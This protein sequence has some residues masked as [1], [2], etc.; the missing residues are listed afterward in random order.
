MVSSSPTQINDRQGNPGLSLLEQLYGIHF[1]LHRDSS[2]DS[3]EE[4][5]LSILAQKQRKYEP[6]IWKDEPVHEVKKL[7]PGIYGL[8]VYHINNVLSPTGNSPD[9][10]DMLTAGVQITAEMKT[11]LFVY[12]MVS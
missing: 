7:S 2:S 12:S 1:F 11:A 9:Q 3:E 5:E 10:Y 6:D 4:E 8:V